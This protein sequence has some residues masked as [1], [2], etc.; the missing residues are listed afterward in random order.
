MNPLANRQLDE[1]KGIR[2]SYQDFCLFLP[3]GNPIVFGIYTDR[4]TVANGLFVLVRAG[5]STVSGVPMLMLRNSTGI[6]LQFRRTAD[7]SYTP[8]KPQ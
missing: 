4:N 6:Q 3:K 5:K 7:C 2:C 8:H 1:N